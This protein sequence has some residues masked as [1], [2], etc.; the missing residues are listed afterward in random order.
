MCQVG[1]NLPKAEIEDIKQ[2]SLRMEEK[3]NLQKLK[4]DTEWPSLSLT[5]Q[6]I[7]V[8][9][10]GNKLNISKDF[11]TLPNMQPNKLQVCGRG[12]RLRQ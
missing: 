5:I 1:V 2:L 8:G 7:P 11:L 4:D 12:R 10:R 9:G 3:M 6:I